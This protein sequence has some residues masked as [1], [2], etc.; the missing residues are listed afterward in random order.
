MRSIGLLT[1]AVGCLFLTA[2]RIPLSKVPLS[3]ATNSKTDERL[4]GSWE[5]DIHRVHEILGNEDENGTVRYRVERADG[6]ENTMQSVYLRDDDKEDDPLPLYTTNIGMHDYLS[7]ASRAG[8]S[9]L[10]CVCRYELMDDNNGKLYLMDD[11]FVVDQI[12][13]GKVSGKV[14]RDDGEIKG[15]MLDLKPQALREFLLRHGDKVFD[16]QHPLACKRIDPS[17]AKE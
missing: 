1:F 3:D 4:V 9:E 12:E 8:A 7:L 6:K 17:I 11:A 15:V 5:V 14:D 16:L 2:C 13:S 10:Y